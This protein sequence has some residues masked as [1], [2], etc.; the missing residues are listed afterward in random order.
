[1]KLPEDPTKA[2]DGHADAHRRADTEEQ[3]RERLVDGRRDER[4]VAM[5]RAFGRI[6]REPASSASE[7][8]QEERPERVT[9]PVVAGERH[10]ANED[11]DSAPAKE[12]ARR[13]VNCDVFARQETKRRCADEPTRE[14][15]QNRNAL[16]HAYKIADQAGVREM[17]TSFE[18]MGR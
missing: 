17:S 4:D 8:Q 6:E 12:E 9:Q 16:P 18:R 7:R 1:V 13:R 14:Q 3:T 10:E 15:A 11:Q 5:E 2:P